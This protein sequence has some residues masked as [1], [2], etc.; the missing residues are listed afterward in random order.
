MQRLT[1]RVEA[2]TEILAILV[3]MAWADEKLK[4]PEKESI[5]SA[6]MVL[7]LTKDHR[8]RLDKMLESPL[9]LD[10]VLV[11][12]LNPKERSFAFVAAAWLA[13]VDD[14]VDAKEQDRLAEIQS[15]LGVDD[16]RADELKAIAKELTAPKDGSWA[17]DLVGLFKSIP[18]RLE[19]SDVDEVEVAFE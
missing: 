2:C 7:N 8:A 17:S 3:V 12:N 18:V 10:Q 15:L 1:I 14:E 6:S 11:S 9:P 4:D 5:R 16:T 19:A 13:G